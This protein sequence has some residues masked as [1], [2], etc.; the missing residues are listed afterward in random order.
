MAVILNSVPKSGTHLAKRCFDTILGVSR[1]QGHFDLRL[2]DDDFVERLVELQGPVWCTSH[3]PYREPFVSL[4][5]RFQHKH[6]VLLRDPRDVAVSFAKYVM[7]EQSHFLHSFFKSLSDD[8]ERLVATI[9]GACNGVFSSSP[10]SLDNIKKTFEKFT[11]WLSTNPS[12]DIRFEKLVGPAGGGSREDQVREISRICGFLGMNLSYEKVLDVAD[13]CFDRNSAT[14]RKGVI[15]DWR[16]HF[17]AEHRE[18]F[19]AVAGDVLIDL[20]YER[21][22]DW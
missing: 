11:R 8:D 3:L 21:D 20:G 10:V 6:V 13:Q 16:N 19:K 14:F 2:S 5:S 4:I 17:R 22:S 9:G 12:C 7:A 1:Y 15:G 18:I